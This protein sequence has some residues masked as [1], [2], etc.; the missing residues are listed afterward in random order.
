[1]TK[2]IMNLVCTLVVAVLLGQA[3]ISQVQ[4]QVSLNVTNGPTTQALV[5]GISGDGPGGIQDNTI[6]ADTDTSIFGAYSEALAPPAPPAP[7]AFDARIITI[8]G[9]V[10]TFPT[11]LGSGVFS[12]FRGWD[13]VLQVDTFKITIAGDDVDL[14]STT[15]SWPT[16]LGAYASSWVIKPQTSS[17]WGPVDMIANT[18]A[19]IP[20]AVLD[21]NILIIK[22]GAGIAG[23]VFA[24][25]PTGLNFGAVNVGS[26]SAIQSVTVSNPST[27]NSLSVLATP[28]ADY[29]IV[30]PSAVVAAGGSQVFDIT[31]TPTAPGPGGNIEFTHNA[32][33]GAD[34]LFVTSF[35][36]DT[37][38]FLSLSP[39][40]L[41]AKDPLKG[42]FFKSNKRGKGLYPNWA[43][44]LEEVVVQGGFQPGMSEGDS[45]GGM[46]VGVSLMDN[47]APGKFKVNKVYGASHGWVR[48]TKW[49]FKKNIGKGYSDL[50]KTMEDKTGS[51]LGLG[52]VRGFN[53]FANGKPFIKQLKKLQPKKQANKLYAEVVALKFNIAASQLGK[54]PVG[55]GELIFDVDGNLFDETE[56]KEIAAEADTMLTNYQTVLQADFD[57]LYSAVYRINRAFLGAIDTFTFE[58]GLKLSVKGVV[59]TT[60]FLKAPIPFVPT[61]IVATTDQTEEDGDFEDDAY[62]D[63][64]GLM[65]VA[66]K[67]YQNYPNPFNPSTTI[68]FRLREASTVNIAV[69]NM[70]GQQVGTLVEGEEFDE[71]F[72]TVEFSASE[73]SSGVYFYRIDAQDIETGERS[74]EAR[75]M[76]LLK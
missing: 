35:G 74:V 47:T 53:T 69:F 7:F 66:A 21:R 45:A 54:T 13:N 58:T 8:P 41:A 12:D 59:N 24:M 50:Q 1:M 73:L 70:L 64:E 20:V 75:K 25:N 27:T 71:G 55:F 9:R 6:G 39:D 43:N 72:N 33:G 48:N 46:V 11:G 2:T 4:F 60:S 34:T 10:S 76:M 30:P 36:A 18:N 22:T 23:P 19:V 38:K 51:H 15:I 61:V 68:S 62:D 14:A 28:D 49:D 3:A 40:T 16:G 17:E 29:S 63:E 65:P 5:V 26:S 42:K 32:L 31:F 57:S 37:S 67:L 56:V 44:L 52:T